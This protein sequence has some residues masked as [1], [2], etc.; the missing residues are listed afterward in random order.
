MKTSIK[1][2]RKICIFPK[3][4]VYGFGQKFQISSSFLYGQNRLRKSVWRRSGIETSLCRLWKHRF[5]KVAKF[6]FFQRG[7]VKFV[8]FHGFGQKFQISS[9]FLFGNN[10]P[11]KCL[12]WCSRKITS[13]SRL[14]KHRLK[15][16][17]KLAFFQRG[18]LM[19]F[20]KNIKFLWPY[21]LGEIGWEKVFG[22]VLGRKLAFLNYEN[23]DYKKS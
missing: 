16:V 12:W 10:S 18:Y 15:N 20:F 6:V 8:F 1:K 5:K 7:L 13:L 9:S 23:V 19:V 17:A 11:G 14:W 3:G 21:F 22:D 2:S 4:L